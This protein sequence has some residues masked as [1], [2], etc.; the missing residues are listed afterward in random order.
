MKSKTSTKGPLK[1]MTV[2]VAITWVG[3]IMTPNF[4]APQLACN[5][6]ISSQVLQ[7]IGSAGKSYKNP[8]CLTVERATFTLVKSISL[9]YFSFLSIFPQ[10]NT[11]VNLIEN[12]PLI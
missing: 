12:F 5:D 7:L 8:Y 6:G 9:R 10:A 11:R 1:N 2:P 4:T 3:K